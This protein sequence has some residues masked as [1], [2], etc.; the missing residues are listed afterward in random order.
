MGTM[1][2][3]VV[4]LA[5][6]AILGA[7][8][9]VL[10]A[11]KQMAEPLPIAN[12]TVFTIPHGRGMNAVA[13]D[14]QRQGIVER[15]RLFSLY[16]RAMGLS[17]RVKAGEYLIEPGQTM[18]GLLEQFVAGRVMMHSVT[19]IEGWTFS[20][21][22][23]TIRAHPAVQ[24][25]PD[26][27]DTTRLVATLGLQ[28]DS[29]EGWL[30]PETYVFPRHTTDVA[31]LAMAADAMRRHLDE[32]WSQRQG[33]LPIETPYQALILASIVEKETAL[34]SERARI[35]G[36]FTRRLERGMRLQT[37]PT[38]IYGLGEAF[39]GNLRRA[40][41]ES[42]TPYNTY[43]RSGL[44][45]TPIALPGRA[46]LEA[47]VMPADGDEL[48]FVATGEPDGSHYFSR[49]LEEHNQAVGRY[50][51]RRRQRQKE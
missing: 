19:L 16:A 1:I 40:D 35:A 38:V 50:L 8:G 2:R 41:L 39:D 3:T 45:P 14:L 6:L 30:F 34:E 28:G 37:D 10:F 32:A 48:Y 25:T 20:D 31:L 29:P 36:V 24:P 22:L 23:D 49:T 18:L 15:P 26:A 42:D 9:L 51:A 44:P 13:A 4:A 21:A 43:T 11:A 12:D 17:S 7:M 46:A 47:A 33:G 5:V 27:L